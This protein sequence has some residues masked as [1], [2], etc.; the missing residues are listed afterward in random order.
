VLEHAG[1]RKGPGKDP[2]ILAEHLSADP[3]N[4]NKI[5]VL[6]EG[7]KY[8]PISISSRAGAVFRDDENFRWMR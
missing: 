2:G 5:A 6:E 4:A 1:R 7:M 8:T 3:A